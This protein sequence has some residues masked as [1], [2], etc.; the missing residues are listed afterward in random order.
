MDE[1][2]QSITLNGGWSLSDC[3]P[4]IARRPSSIYTLLQSVVTRRLTDSDSTPRYSLSL[5]P[6]V[7]LRPFA[8]KNYYAPSRPVGVDRRPYTLRTVKNRS[9]L[10]ST[11]TLADLNRHL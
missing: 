8:R 2:S 5:G 4:S 10:C 1:Y 3:Q 7:V 11:V 6:T 9:G